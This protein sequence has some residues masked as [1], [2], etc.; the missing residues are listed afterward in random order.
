MTD[1]ALHEDDD[2]VEQIAAEIVA[3]LRRGE[4]PTVARNMPR[5]TRP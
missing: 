1:P 3:R 4:R 2:R 5:R